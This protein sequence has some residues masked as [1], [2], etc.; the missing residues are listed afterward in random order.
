MGV[1]TE[2]HDHDYVRMSRQDRLKRFLPWRNWDISID[3]NPNGPWLV[4]KELIQS[5]GQRGIRQRPAAH[6]LNILLRDADQHDT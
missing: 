4:L 1:T 3:I 2:F 6:R 5:P